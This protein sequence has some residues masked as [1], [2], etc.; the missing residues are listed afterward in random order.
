MDN[1][2]RAS[3]NSFLFVVKWNIKVRWRGLA[4]ATGKGRRWENWSHRFIASS[5][6][7]SASTLY[8]GWVSDIGSSVQFYFSCLLWISFTYLRFHTSF[9]SVESAVGIGCLDLWCLF[10]WQWNVYRNVEDLLKM[11]HDALPSFPLQVHGIYLENFH[12]FTSD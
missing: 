4:E 1:P 2:T 5:I 10:S 8:Y 9:L 7:C 11:T 3:S 6:L 12:Y